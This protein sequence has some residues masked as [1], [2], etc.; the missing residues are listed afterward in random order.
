M[1]S[2]TK[3]DSSYQYCSIP[4]GT[5]KSVNVLRDVICSPRVDAGL[6][7]KAEYAKFLNNYIDEEVLDQT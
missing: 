7:E 4:G 1:I 6:A 3:G 2:T 5:P